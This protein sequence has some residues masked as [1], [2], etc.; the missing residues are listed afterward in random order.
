MCVVCVCVCARERAKPSIKSALPGGRQLSKMFVWEGE[1]FVGRMFAMRARTRVCVR[2]SSS[3]AL[4]HSPFSLLF[5]NDLPGAFEALTLLFVGAIKMTQNIITAWD[6]MEK[7]NLPGNPTK[8]II[9]W[10]VPL[11]LSFFLDG[12][13]TPH[14]CFQIG[15]RSKGSDRQ[16]TSD[17]MHVQPH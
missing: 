13:G 14:P 5:V 1:T 7:G 15:Q 16:C 9:G 12:F 8:C 2:S 6:R 17:L 11:S 10:D 4:P 3:P